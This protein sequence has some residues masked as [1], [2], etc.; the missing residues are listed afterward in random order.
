MVVTYQ[1]SPCQ[2]QTGW[3]VRKTVVMVAVVGVGGSGAQ[4]ESLVGGTG[5]VALVAEVA[6]VVV[7]EGR[8]LAGSLQLV[9]TPALQM[10]QRGR[11]GQSAR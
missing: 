4:R 6:A 11:E 9:L 2:Y 3:S 5:A 1:C 7:A 8:R 10:Q